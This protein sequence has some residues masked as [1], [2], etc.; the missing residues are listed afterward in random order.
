MYELKHRQ[1]MQRYALKE[2]EIRNG[3]QR[4]LAVSEAEMLK[5]ST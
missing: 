5:V 4:E 3:K 2:I 1:T